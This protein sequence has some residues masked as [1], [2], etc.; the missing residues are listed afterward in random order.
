MCRFVGVPRSTVDK[1][2]TTESG[3]LKGEIE[4]LEKRMHYLEMTYK[5]SRENLEAILKSGGK[6]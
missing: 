3:E 4:G 2:I 1:R 6:A 5:N